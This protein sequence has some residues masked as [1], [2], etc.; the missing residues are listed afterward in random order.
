V[1]IEDVAICNLA[2]EHL[3]VVG[4]G[5]PI[6]LVVNVIAHQNVPELVLGY[7]IKDRLGQAVFGT[8]THHLD[9]KLDQ[10]KAGS[11]MN[12]EFSFSANLGV[13]S[14]SISVALHTSDT[15]IGQNYEWR[16]LAVVF[17]VINIDKAYFVGVNWLPPHLEC[18]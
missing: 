5:Q 4:V 13:G 2:G 17:D 14:Y 9:S 6:K 10:I 12:Y 1:T 8:N 7:V 3:E 15:H 11:R 18:K 16:D